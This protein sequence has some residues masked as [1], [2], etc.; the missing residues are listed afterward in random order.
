V[1]NNVNHGFTGWMHQTFTYTATNTSELLSFLA[2]GTPNGVPPFVLLD[3]VVVNDA[4]PE[5]GSLT[6]MLGG[7]G[8]IGLGVLRSKKRLKN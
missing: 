2:V 8:L 1:V 7:L 3:G 4:T 5:P 6:L